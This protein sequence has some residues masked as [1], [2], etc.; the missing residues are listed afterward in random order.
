[1]KSVYRFFIFVLGLILMPVFWLGFNF[2]FYGH[3]YTYVSLSFLYRDFIKEY[4]NGT[5]FE[6]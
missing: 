2:V 3:I 4:K 6:D 5:L 1:M